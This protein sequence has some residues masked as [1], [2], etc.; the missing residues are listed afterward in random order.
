MGG[1]R[2][3][4]PEW[5]G[6]PM[7]WAEGEGLAL[8]RAKLDALA[9]AHPQTPHWRPAPLLTA[10]ADARAP[11]AAWKAHLPRPAATTVAASRL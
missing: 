11:L 1:R 7:H 10:L 3:G 8:V 9:L 6:G 2:Y 5:R 4:F